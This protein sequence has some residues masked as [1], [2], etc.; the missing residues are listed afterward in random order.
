MLART[1]ACLGFG[2]L[3]LWALPASA[4]YQW[5]FATGSAFVQ[6]A[7]FCGAA[8]SFT[9]GNCFTY[10]STPSG[11]GSVNVNAW[12]STGPSGTNATSTG[13]LQTAYVDAYSGG[14]GVTDRQEATSNTGTSGYLRFT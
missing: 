10:N 9:Y 13:P 7:S 14:L 12:A 3:G 1:K 2:L 11:G 5:Q 6:P 8:Q 4:A